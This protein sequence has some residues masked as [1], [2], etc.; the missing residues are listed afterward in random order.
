MSSLHHAI[1]RLIVAAE[2]PLVL[3]NRRQMLGQ[4]NEA[5]WICTGQLIPDPQDLTPHRKLLASQL[6]QDSLCFHGSGHYR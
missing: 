1:P 5:E 2:A 4:F 6:D 3:R